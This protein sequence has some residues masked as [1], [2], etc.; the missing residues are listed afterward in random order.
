MP[1]VKVP[2]DI[3]VF[4]YPF[5]PYARRVL[6]YLELRGIPYAQCVNP[7]PASPRPDLAA[8]GVRYRR[9][10]LMAIG[11]D[12]YLDSRLILSTLDSHPS[13]SSYKPLS[14]PQSAGIA[15][16]FDKFSTDSGV[17]TR[18]A[19]LIPLE[20]KIWEDEKFQKDRED[21]TGRSWRK[22]DVA[23]ARPEALAHMRLAFEAVEAML[24]DG[25]EWIAAT[26]EVSLADVEAVWVFDWLLDMKT[27]PSDLISADFF[28]KTY[29]WIHRFREALRTARSRNSKPVNL[30]GSDAVAH[31]ASA[32][33]N[34]TE[35]L[36]VVPVDPLRLKEGTRSRCGRSILGAG[37]GTGAG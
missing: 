26:R 16:L 19:Q 3:I 21:M 18:A 12:I 33:F 22:A 11:R 27:L 5:S 32:S 2:N 10:P 31:V 28:P 25:R 35:A 13:L 15:M 20:S 29:A 30:A 6:W 17:F 1:E 8:L 24:N 14:T 34:A 36:A 4:Q 7:T 23:K 9:I 37:T